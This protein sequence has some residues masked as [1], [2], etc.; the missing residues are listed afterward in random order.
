MKINKELK[1]WIELFC[2]YDKTDYEN[3]S[4]VQMP[5][6][7]N[8]DT[9]VLDASAERRTDSNSVMGTK[10]KVKQSYGKATSLE[11]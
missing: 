10:R 1:E 8:V 11:N 7:W 2:I 9:L 5:I 3:L 4:E 6:W